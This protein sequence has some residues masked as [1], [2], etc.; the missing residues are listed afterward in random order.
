MF[1]AVAGANGAIKR[2]SSLA[3]GIIYAGLCVRA[4]ELV[5]GHPTSGGASSNPAPWI[6][7]VMRWSGGPVAIGV[8]GAILVGAGMGLA[9]WG[10]FHRYEKNLALERLGHRWQTAVRVLGGMGE[11]ARGSLLA[12]VGV[13]LIDAGVASNPAQAKGV[14]QALRALVH[15]R[16]GALAIALIALGLLAFGLFSFFD[17]RLRRL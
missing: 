1:N 17:A 12:L 9:V 10:L 5:A 2:L 15:D 11:V 3:V 7:R 6:A 14:D 4:A 13:Y 8:G 16:F